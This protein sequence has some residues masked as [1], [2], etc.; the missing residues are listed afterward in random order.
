MG[1]SNS[2]AFIYSA[3]NQDRDYCSLC[4]IDRAAARR[5]PGKLINSQPVLD[6]KVGRDE[7]L[8]SDGHHRLQ[9]KAGKR[10]GAAIR[11]IA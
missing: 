10:D 3:L 7:T 8:R 5:G 4:I 6:G 2:R 9:G 1:E 11:M